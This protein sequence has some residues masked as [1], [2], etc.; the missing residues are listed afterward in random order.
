M[1]KNDTSKRRKLRIEA[2]PN[3]SITAEELQEILAKQNQ[4]QGEK[5]KETAVIDLDSRR[6]VAPEAGAI[7]AEPEVGGSGI[8]TN[9]D[10]EIHLADVPESVSKSEIKEPEYFFERKL[11]TAIKNTY[12]LTKK[13]LELIKL[14]NSKKKKWEIAD[15]VNKEEIDVDLLRRMFLVNLDDKE[16]QAELEELRKFERYNIG[17]LRQK[18][19]SHPDVIALKNSD[20]TEREKKEE[21]SDL[22]DKILG[23]EIRDIF[24]KDKVADAGRANEIAIILA[25]NVHSRLLKIVNNKEKGPIGGEQIEISKSLK[26]Q[27]K[28][29]FVRHI[30]KNNDE[31]QGI[32][33]SSLGRELVNSRV[34]EIINKIRSGK[35]EE[36]IIDFIQE[37]ESEQTDSFPEL[38]I[39]V[40]KKLGEIIA[41][42]F[43]DI[44]TGKEKN[45]DEIVEAKATENREAVLGK[46]FEILERKIA[47]NFPQSKMGFIVRFEMFSREMF[48][49]INKECEGLLGKNISDEERSDFALTLLKS[50]IAKKYA[51]KAETIGLPKEMAADI[52]EYI[53]ERIKI[54]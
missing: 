25:A 44:L 27:Q 5:G 4:D 12:R 3:G 37:Q 7:H 47:E 45:I 40:E 39:L 32:I 23:H 24:R 15:G 50:R 54:F 8:L 1:A 28:E 17:E 29:D 33:F 6:P 46:K 53:T 36:E 52:A 11:H 30:L 31:L 49:K 38:H 9:K 22:V 41:R 51:E 14:F 10:S 34:F 16:L 42:D 19:N 43:R 13:G 2:P 20:K 21:Y 26:E 48:G 18:I 35:V